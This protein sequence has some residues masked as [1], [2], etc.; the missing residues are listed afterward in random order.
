MS[1][2]TKPPTFFVPHVSFWPTD[3]TVLQAIVSGDPER[4]ATAVAGFIEK[5][6]A[7]MQAIA[8]AACIACGEGPASGCDVFAAATGKPPLVIVPLCQRCKDNPAMNALAV[9]RQA[10]IYEIEAA[11]GHPETRGPSS[12]TRH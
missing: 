9:E 1:A 12:Q 8:T 2:S 5:N 10:G 6:F 3:D 11:Q 7:K 4:A